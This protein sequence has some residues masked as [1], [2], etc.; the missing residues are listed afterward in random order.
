MLC[1]HSMH[2]YGSPGEYV[3]KVFHLGTICGSSK[4]HN[5]EGVLELKAGDSV[6]AA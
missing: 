3:N 6:H 2:E 5:V 1:G 4:V